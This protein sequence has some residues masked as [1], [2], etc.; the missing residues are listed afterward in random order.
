VKRVVCAKL[1]LFLFI[2][3]IAFSV[4][5]CGKKRFKKYCVHNRRGSGKFRIKENKRTRCER[6]QERVTQKAYNKRV[7][8]K[9]KKLEASKPESVKLGDVLRGM[10]LKIAEASEHTVK[11]VPKIKGGS[12]E[13]LVKTGILGEFIRAVLSLKTCTTKYEDDK[14]KIQECCDGGIWT[15]HCWD[16]TIYKTVAV[17]CSA[18]NSLSWIEGSDCSPETIISFANNTESLQGKAIGMMR[19]GF[20]D[21]GTRSVAIEHLSFNWQDCALLMTVFLGAVI[22]QLSCVI[23]CYCLCKNLKKDAE[24]S[25]VKSLKRKGRRRKRRKKVEI[26]SP[27]ESGFD[28]DE[29]SSD[30]FEDSSLYDDSSEVSS[31]S[32]D[33]LIMST[34][35]DISD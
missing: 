21:L 26:N 17:A 2:N 20:D 6:R 11:I 25:K 13:T 14:V 19:Y 23:T 3:S 31:D 12:V 34:V 35:S 28:R 7:S 32:F 30:S 24:C 1:V 15:Y 27:V 5:Q 33:E 29:L 22:L 4:I 16:E 18:L 8:K 10:L 9:L